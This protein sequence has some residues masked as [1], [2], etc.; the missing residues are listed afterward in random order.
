M[1]VIIT[2]NGVVTAKRVYSGD[3]SSVANSLAQEKASTPGM[4]FQ[5]F[6]S[7]LDPA[8]VAIIV[9]LTQDELDAQT[10][11]Q[12][13]KLI[14][15]KNMTPAQ[16]H[17]FVDNNIVDFASAKDAIKTLAVAVGILARRI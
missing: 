15:L 3:V 11:R 16:V 13:Q 4:D 14:A 1:G 9:P 17:N 8:F 6:Q 2:L 7:E 10:A 5:I 12:Y